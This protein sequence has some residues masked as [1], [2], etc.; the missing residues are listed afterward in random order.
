[1]LRSRTYG[2]TLTDR[3]SGIVAKVM[4]VMDEEEEDVEVED[5]D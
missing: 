5:F 1:M 3:P 4:V 2:L